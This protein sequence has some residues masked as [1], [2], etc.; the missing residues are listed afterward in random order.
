MVGVVLRLLFLMQ[1]S[2]RISNEIDVHDVD[3]V[4]RAER[5]R[6]QAGQENESFHHV[7]LRRLRIAA[8]PK[9]D[10]GTEDGD[11][12]SGNNS[13]TMCSPNFLVRA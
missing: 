6:L 4:V 1:G 5:K 9:N 8:V 13:R 11:G 12:K 2:D 7:E 3:L 10:A